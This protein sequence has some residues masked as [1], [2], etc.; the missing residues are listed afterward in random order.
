[1]FDFLKGMFKDKRVERLKQ[2]A[3]MDMSNLLMNYGFTFEEA[4]KTAKDFW[5]KN[6]KKLKELV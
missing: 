1:M 3:I 5:S 2:K 6:E 4:V